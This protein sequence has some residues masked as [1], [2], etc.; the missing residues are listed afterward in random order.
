MGC[1]VSAIVT[2]EMASDARTR[3]LRPFDTLAELY[4]ALDNLI[5]FPVVG[6]TESVDYV[7]RGSEVSAQRIPLEKLD[8]DKQPRTLVCHDMK[9]GYLEDR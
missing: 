4:S 9:G 6:I 3:E 7:Y 5:E 1:S 2:A 8:R